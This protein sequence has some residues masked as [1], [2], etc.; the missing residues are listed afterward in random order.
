MT[1]TTIDRDRETTNRDSSE[2]DEWII[3]AYYSPDFTKRVGAE[4]DRLMALAPNWDSYGAQRIDAQIVHAA[5]DFL[6][7][8]PENLVAPP[9]VV[10]M[11]KG[12]LQF[13]WHEG[14][15]SLEL[16]FESPTTIHYLKWHPEEGVE[17]EGFFAADDVSQAVAFIRWFVKGV[18]NV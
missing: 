11:A 7:R 5:H 2:F 14:S 16:E 15:R 12:N 8:L 9:L 18:A 13:E 6:S 3:T 10:P 4:L 1:P 17:E